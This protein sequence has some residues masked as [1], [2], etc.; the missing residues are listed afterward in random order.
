METY[1]RLAT[2]TTTRAT[3]DA[4]LN[5]VEDGLFGRILSSIRKWMQIPREVT[6]RPLVQGERGA[7]H[8]RQFPDSA[9]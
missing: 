4:V 7:R 8:T 5:F 2:S 1:T 6:R 9:G 3:C